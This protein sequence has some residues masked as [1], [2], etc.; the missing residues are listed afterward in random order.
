[1]LAVWLLL[2][3]AYGYVAW[4][5]IREPMPAAVIAVLGGTFAAV[6]VGSFAGLFTGAR[7]RAA[8]RRALNGE[9]FRD[10]RLEAA[11]G[12]IRPIDAALQAPFTGRPCV[13]YEYDVK[14]PGGDRSEFAGV[15]LA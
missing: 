13:A 5:R 1:M 2:V 9:A 8:I 12:A 4:E 7:D 6:L 10:G 15:A 11:S 3:G 14:L